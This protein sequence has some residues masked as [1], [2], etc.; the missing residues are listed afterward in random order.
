MSPLPLLLHNLHILKISIQHNIGEERISNK[1]MKVRIFQKTN[2]YLFGKNI[3]FSKI[4]LQNI[5]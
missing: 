2:L 5:L 3:V 4:I 1:F